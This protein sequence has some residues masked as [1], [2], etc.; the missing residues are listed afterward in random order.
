MNVLQV[1]V[2]SALWT[3]IIVAMLVTR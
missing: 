3:V 1:S 2:I